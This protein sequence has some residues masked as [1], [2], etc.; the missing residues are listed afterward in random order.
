MK[1]AERLDLPVELERRLRQGIDRLGQMRQAMEEL[2]RIAEVIQ[3]LLGVGAEQERARAT[4]PSRPAE[5]RTQGARTAAPPPPANE[6]RTPT[7]SASPAPTS[8]EEIPEWRKM[9]PG[10]SAQYPGRSK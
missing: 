1:N 6:P 8:S 3:P 5:G 10:L 4:P 7:G 2:V 9:F